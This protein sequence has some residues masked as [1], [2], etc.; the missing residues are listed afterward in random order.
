MKLAKILTL[1]IILVILFVIPTFITDQ[2]LMHVLII[3]AINI[4]MAVSLRAITTTGQVSLGHACFMSIGAYT[5]G[6]VV[7]KLGFSTYAGLILGGIAATA[8]ALI[9]AYPITRVKTVYFAMLTMFL[10]EVIRLVFTEARD[11][12]GGTNGMHNIPH[13]G[14]ISIPGLFAIQFTAKVPNYYFIL[15]I[16]LIIILIL[17]SIDRSRIGMICKS[18]DQDNSLAA[19]IGVHTANFKAIMFCTG[20]FFAGIAGS[21]YACYNT[22]LTPDS[23]GLF[24]SIYVIVYIVVGGQQ[25][26]AG[27]IIGALILTLIPELLRSLKEYQPFVFVG[28]LYLVVFLLPGGLVSLPQ[29]LKSPVGNIFKGRVHHAGN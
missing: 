4:I 14:T 29:Y 16:M 24:P 20:C 19:S 11:V 3:C 13:L 12:T 9:I 18:I 5:A 23:F 27:A 7:T 25:R 17:Y 1:V 8:M 28:V 2:Y 15:V 26:F 6:I 10:G 22:I 21:F